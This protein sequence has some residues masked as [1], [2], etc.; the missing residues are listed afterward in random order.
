MC[1][2]NTPPRR[3]KG[4]NAARTLTASTG[5]VSGKE[6]GA[7]FIDDAG[8]PLNA[9]CMAHGQANAEITEGNAPT[10]SC[11]HEAPVVSF[12]SQRKVESISPIAD[13]S[14]TLTNGT[15]PGFTNAICYDARGNGNGETVNTITGNHAGHV[16]DYMPLVAFTANDNGRDCLSECS[17]TLRKGGETPADGGA[18]VPAIVE[19]EP[20]AFIKNDAGGDQDGYWRGIFPTLRTEITPA[21][22]Y[23]VTFCDANGCRKDRPNGGLYVT[24]TDAGKTVTAGGP[25]TE[26]LVVDPL[27]TPIALDG[28]KIAKSERKGGSGLGVKQD[29]S[30]YTQTA[31][32]VHAVAYNE[33]EPN[34]KCRA[35]V[36]R[37]L[38]IETERLMGFPD[39][40]TRIP[41]QGKPAEEC[42]D[43][44]RYKACGNSMAVNVMAWLG[45]RIQ[46]VEDTIK[47]Q[48]S[49]ETL[50]LNLK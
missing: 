36:R 3:A 20:L 1:G 46:A 11:N 35:T 42:P 33:R 10:L 21:I 13:V 5:G 49:K 43:S 18:I 24:E 48:S 41:W 6:Q 40:H 27:E 25:N 28:D 29:G 12:Y 38:P 2:G 32:D 8:T 4:Q 23:N 9:L 37:L 30:M 14:N 22:A 50:C 15:C 44:A 16:N 17:P 34:V 39:H 26:M 7:T 45:H 31:R 47:N 19:S